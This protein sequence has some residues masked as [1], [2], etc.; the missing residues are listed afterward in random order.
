MRGEVW[1]R[2]C[3]GE[4]RGEAVVAAG[5]NNLESG[6]IPVALPVVRSH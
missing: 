5:A 3:D 2:K 6:A 1:G 4:D